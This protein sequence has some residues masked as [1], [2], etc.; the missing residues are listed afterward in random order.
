MKIL[1][2]VL[3]W[4]DEISIYRFFNANIWNIL[5]NAARF[6]DVEIK[7]MWETEK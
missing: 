6:E 4:Q 3:L 2:V 1:Y 7:I 5:W